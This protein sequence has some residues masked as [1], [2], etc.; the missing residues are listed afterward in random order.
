V[1]VAAFLSVASKAAGFVGLLVLMFVGFLPQ[2]EVWAPVFG[3]LSVLTMTLGNLVAL[4]Q[5]QIVRL[6]A[7]SSIAQAGYILLPFALAGGT[8]SQNQ[9][10]F[11]AAVVYILIYAVMNLGAFAVVVLMAREAPGAMV[12]DYDGLI[13][14][15]PVVAVAMTMF[16][17]S[18]AGIPPTAGF[19]GKFFIFKAAIGRETVAAAVLAAIMVVNSV[20][21]LGYYLK[22]V[23]AMI[24]TEGRDRSRIRIPVLLGAVLLVG[25][26]LVVVLFVMPDLVANLPSGVVLAGA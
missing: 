9:E 6:L 15:A 23:R 3:L 10:A 22:V 19:W 1:P 8:A 5:T 24:F 17:V 7:Y 12:R 16:L 13:R 11:F 25:A 20:I 26:V 18:L 14:R 4:K 2:A 21:S